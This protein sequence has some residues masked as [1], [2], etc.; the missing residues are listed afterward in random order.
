M[1]LAA[2]RKYNKAISESA[3]CYKTGRLKRGYGVEDIL[4]MLSGNSKYSETHNAVMDAED[5]L[6]IM[7]LLGWGIN[8]YDIASV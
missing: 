7:Q 5:E 3:D 2:Y 6:K 1:R 4:Q 8:E